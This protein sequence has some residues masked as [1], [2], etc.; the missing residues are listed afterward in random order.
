MADHWVIN[1]SPIILLAKAEVIQF[2]PGLC[3]ELVIPAG[4]VDEV[5][6]VLITDAGKIW[7]AGE[8]R[9][10]VRPSPEIHSALSSWRGGTGEAGVISWAL[11][12]PRFTAVLDDRRA[13]GQHGSHEGVLGGPHAGELQQDPGSGELGGPGDHVAVLHLDVGHL[14]QNLFLI[15]AELRL[16]AFITAAINEIDLEHAFDLDPMSEGPLCVIGLGARA[17][18]QVTVEFDPQGRVWGKALSTDDMDEKADDT[19][20]GR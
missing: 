8:G 17:Q 2:L 11:H 16:G 14:S 15:A 1:A 3:D 10:F 19:D 20:G 13:L 12:D 4:V 7:L 6:N 5:H 9:Q 18:E